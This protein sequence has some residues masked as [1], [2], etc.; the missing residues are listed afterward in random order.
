MASRNLACACSVSPLARWTSAIIRMVSGSLSLASRTCVERFLGAIVVLVRVRVL[1]DAAPGRVEVGRFLHDLVESPVALVG[2]SEEAVEVD[3][4]YLRARAHRS[5]LGGD[6]EFLLGAGRLPL[7][8]I[9]RTESQVGVGGFGL[10]AGG[11]LKRGLGPGDVLLPKLERSHGQVELRLVRVIGAGALEPPHRAVHF[12]LGRH[13]AGEDRERVQVLRVLVES[14]SGLFARFLHPAPEEVQRRQAYPGLEVVGIE[15]DGSLEV[16]EGGSEL[17]GVEEGLRQPRGRVA[18]GLVELDDVQKLD[19]G[20][21]GLPFLQ[22]FVAALEVSRDLRPLW[23]RRSSRRE[24]WRARA[25]RGA[26]IW[27]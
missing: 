15:L 6:V 23:S 27:V 9:E 3:D 11:F 19:D 8:Q 5:L 20:F 17:T 16:L 12:T 14:V 25:R 22:V 10:D 2:L 1:G 7:R 13:R 26:R 4:A 24:R 18:V 21:P